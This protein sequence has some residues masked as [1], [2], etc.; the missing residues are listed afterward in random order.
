MTHYALGILQAIPDNSEMTITGVI[1]TLIASI[2][3]FLIKTSRDMSTCQAINK[4][5]LDSIRGVL[6]GLDSNAKAQTNLLDR[7]DRSL[8]RIERDVD[9]VVESSPCVFSNISSA[10]AITDTIVDEIKVSNK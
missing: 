2:I 6:E 8:E 4:E 1:I 5:S 7:M 10:K 9:K 3:G